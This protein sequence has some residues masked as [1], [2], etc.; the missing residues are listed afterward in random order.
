MKRLL[1]LVARAATFGAVAGVVFFALASL[2]MPE[3][4]H[5]RRPVVLNTPTQVERIESV[6]SYSSGALRA[7]PSVVSVYA[8]QAVQRR[9]PGNPFWP[10]GA[11]E[12]DQSGGLGSGVV[13]SADGYV[14][15]NN[16]VVQGAGAVAV[17]VGEGRP[18]RAQV[19][20]T[21]PETDLAVL[22]IDVEGLQPI[23]IGDSDGARI[24]DIVL[25]IGNPFGV[26]QTV[27]QGIV[28]GTGRNRVGINTFENFIQT[29]AAINPGNSGGALVD[30]AGRLIGIN[31]A[32]LSPSGG[33]LG[34]G[35]AIPVR[36]AAE[37]MTQLVTGGRVDRGWLGV[38]AQTLTPE[39]ARAL[40]VD[41][42][43]GA[44]LVRLLRGGPAD[45]GGMMPGDV[46][47]AVDGKPVADTVDLINRTATIKPGEDGR[48]TVLRGR[49][50]VELTVKTGRRPP[51]D[52]QA[53]RR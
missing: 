4:L 15:T 49:G 47:V 10:F 41:K 5:L 24:G 42:Q 39:L 30:A 53:R 26:G 9:A 51:I 11:P 29:D 38:E 48:Y 52:Q 43:Q 50:E 45:A 16:H 25:A 35:F 46:V 17:E 14:L 12:E 37:V 19:V 33:S 23:A 34:I 18:A 6:A 22:K 1:L 36:T 27:T 7:M 28:S 32:I 31:T 21:D 44:V 2:I 8:V 13:M 20:G 40:G 3:W